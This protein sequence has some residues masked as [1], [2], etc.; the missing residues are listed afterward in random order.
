MSSRT[1]SP[2]PTRNAAKKPDLVSAPM[3][4]VLVACVVAALGYSKGNALLT[5]PVPLGIVVLAVAYTAF[6]AMRARG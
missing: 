2:A 6:R 3:T 4:A 5:W 1:D